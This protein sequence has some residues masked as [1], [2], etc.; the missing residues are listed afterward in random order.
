MK[1]LVCLRLV[2]DLQSQFNLNH[3]KD[4]YKTHG[5]PFRLN[6]YDEYAL[7][8]AMR[9]KESLNDVEI[10]ALSVGDAKAEQAVRRGLEFGADRGVHVVVAEKN[11]S[12]PDGL[13]VASHIAS[14]AQTES[15][16]LLFFGVM[17]EDLQRSQVGAMTAHLLNLPCATSVV[18]LDLSEDLRKI[19][20]HR[21]L[22]GGRREIVEMPLPAVVTV[23]SGINRPRYPSLSNKLRARKQELEVI[24]PSSDEMA[25][26]NEEFSGLREPPQTRAGIFIEGSI[27]EK[28]EKLIEIIHEKT[29]LI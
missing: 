6:S 1:I 3:T 13:A 20:V 12:S 16:D 5:I 14:F 21:E 8:E 10:T 24:I 7:E 25:Q 15:Y 26:L 4:H 27:Y 23:Q 2:P 9:I 29:R 28:A 19:T 11:I 18:K 22:E 17:S